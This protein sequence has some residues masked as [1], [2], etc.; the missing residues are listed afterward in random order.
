MIFFGF[1]SLRWI[2]G[3]FTVMGYFFANIIY[4]PYYLLHFTAK[5]KIEKII[6]SSV[7]KQ[8]RPHG[9]EAM[10]A[11]VCRNGKRED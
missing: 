10:G 2:I 8:Q 11:F 7:T 6:S 3:V 4:S 9:V 1:L 5:K